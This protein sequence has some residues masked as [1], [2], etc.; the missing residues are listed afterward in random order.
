ML[1][2]VKNILAGQ[3]VIVVSGLPRSGTSMMMQMLKAAGLDILCDGRREADPDNPKG[4]F[5]YEPV[6]SLRQDNSWLEAAQGKVVKIIS[7]LLNYL[8]PDLSYKIILMK[9][10]LNEIL[11]S[12]Q[13]MIQRL[14]TAGS[15]ASEEVMARVFAKH[16]AET[17]SWL[18]TQKHME[19]LTVHFQ[20]AVSKP[21]T[22]A[23]TVARFL[24]PHLAIERMVKVVDPTLYRNN[25]TDR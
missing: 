9:R 17:E 13:K 4:Y 22:T 19:V 23:E 8:D 5:E 20:D 3:P 25:G 7:A 18:Q 6:K 15:G 21:D 2:Q 16:L 14:G 24:D 10:P 12:Q 1:P 11:A